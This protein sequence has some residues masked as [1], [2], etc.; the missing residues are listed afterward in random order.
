MKVLCSS[1]KRTWETAKSGSCT[2]KSQAFS[3]AREVSKSVLFIDEQFGET[4]IA[5][6]DGQ[7]DPEPARDKVGGVDQAVVPKSKVSAQ[8]TRGVTIAVEE[9]KFK[10][11]E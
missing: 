8:Q 5:H 10:F 3:F 2:K 11:I 9:T 4:V 6:A 7:V 1:S